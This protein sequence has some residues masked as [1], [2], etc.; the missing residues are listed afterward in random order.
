MECWEEV[1]VEIVFMRASE[2]PAVVKDERSAIKA[3]LTGSDIL[4]EAGWGKDA[5]IEVPIYAQ[6]RYYSGKPEKQPALYIGMVREFMERIR[7]QKGRSPAAKDLSGYMLATKLPNIAKEYF[8]ERGI[9]D[10]ELLP[11]GGTDEAMQ[12]AYPNCYGS[13]GVINSG[14]TV[15]DNEIGILDTFYPVTVRWIQVNSGLNQWEQ[16]VLE[17]LKDRVLR[18]R[19]YFDDVG[20]SK[21]SKEP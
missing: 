13:L 8:L 10:V 16:Q 6:D 12:Y 9:Q 20:E 3:G 18:G 17:D 15:E 11:V 14:R 2:I 5:G 21:R 7:N 1:P 4:W 19:S